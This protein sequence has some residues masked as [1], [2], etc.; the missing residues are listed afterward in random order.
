MKKVLKEKILKADL[1]EIGVTIMSLS[2]GM[3][4][5]VLSVL[6][7]IGAITSGVNIVV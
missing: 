6:F 7:I 5:L 4:L 3:F 2:I 1:V